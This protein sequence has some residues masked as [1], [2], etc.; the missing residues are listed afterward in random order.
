MPHTGDRTIIA[1]NAT[2]GEDLIGRDQTGRDSVG[3]D[4]VGRDAVGGNSVHIA[5]E[6]MAEVSERETDQIRRLAEQINRLSDDLTALTRALIGDSRFGATGL[7]QQVRAM[8]ETNTRQERWRQMSVW[9]LALVAVSQVAQ[10]YLLWRVWEL[11]W[12]IYAAVGQ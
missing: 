9:A 2:V 7:V 8:S 6:R 12:A 11:Y 1:G 4:V 5:M 10:W 3:R